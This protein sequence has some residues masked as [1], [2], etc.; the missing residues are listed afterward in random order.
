MKLAAML[1]LVLLSMSVVAGERTPWLDKVPE[2]L[3]SWQKWEN[4]PNSNFFEIPVSRLDTV[5]SWLAK[6][7]Y[8]QLEKE[9]ASYWGH[10]E[11]KC[12][13]ATKP[14]LLRAAYVNGG[15]GDFSLDWADNSL[16]VSHVSL[17]PGGNSS[18]SGL[19]ACLSKKPEK[20][21]SSL[22]GAM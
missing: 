18:K 22:S 21:Y 10:P 9:D 7:P 12:R 15:T 17:G 4:V 13:D 1:M 11:F 19:Y 2:S 5:M 8:M 6:K 14:Y 3:G 20:V 16:I